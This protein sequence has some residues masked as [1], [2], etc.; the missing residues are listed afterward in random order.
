MMIFSRRF[1][2]SLTL[3]DQSSDDIRTPQ[4][5][6]TLKIF[7]YNSQVHFQFLHHNAGLSLEAPCRRKGAGISH[8]EFDIEEPAVVVQRLEE[9]PA[10]IGHDQC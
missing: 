7:S 6:L 9:V 3:N 2:Y 1:A 8:G 5:A 10:E 4:L